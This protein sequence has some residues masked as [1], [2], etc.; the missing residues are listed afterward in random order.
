MKKF[1]PLL[2]CSSFLASSAVL[3][4]EA[5]MNKAPIDTVFAQGEINPYGNSLPVLLI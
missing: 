3:A 4:G 2:L 1:I 5:N